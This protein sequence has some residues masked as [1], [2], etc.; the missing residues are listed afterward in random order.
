LSPIKISLKDYAFNKTRE[1]DDE[2][3]LSL[4][5][6][7]EVGRTPFRDHALLADGG[8]YDNLGMAAMLQRWQKKD[9]LLLISDGGGKSMPNSHQSTNWLGQVLRVIQVADAQARNQR[10]RGILKSLF[11]QMGKSTSGLR[12]GVYWSTYSNLENLSKD[13]NMALSEFLYANNLAETRRLATLPTRLWPL[14]DQTDAKRLI[15]WGYAITDAKIRVFAGVS[16]KGVLP[17]PD[18]T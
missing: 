9:Y 8:L 5:D 1:R 3:E 10:L 13:A 17:Y 18:I 7:D 12:R 16:E 6:M 2:E 4:D 11:S 15:N 14:K